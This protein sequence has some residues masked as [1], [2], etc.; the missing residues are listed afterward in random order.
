MVLV[1]D[2]MVGCG[3]PVVVDVKNKEGLTALWI[4]YVIKTANVFVYGYSSGCV[5]GINR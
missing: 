2:I 5:Q 1:D 4:Y 3:Q